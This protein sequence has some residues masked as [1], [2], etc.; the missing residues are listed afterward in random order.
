MSHAL[1]SLTLAVAMCMVGCSAPPGCRPPP[2]PS[3]LPTSGDPIVVNATDA[4]VVVN[5]S[6]AASSTVQPSGWSFCNSD[7]SAGLSCTFT[8]GPNGTQVLPTG[9]SPLNAT[10]AFNGQVTCGTTQVELNINNPAWYDI[11]DISLVNGYSNKVSVSCDG[12]M[13]GPVVGP[14][15][16]EKVFGVYPLGCDLCA[17]RSAQTPCGMQPGTDGCKAGTQYD[18]AVPCQY[19]GSTMGGGTTIVVTYEGT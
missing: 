2:A 11:V 16:N 6:F 4:S 12:T 10:M 8:I 17:A 19:Q 15:G 3:P 5:V 1:H 14:T 13:L 7:A 9:G 18:P